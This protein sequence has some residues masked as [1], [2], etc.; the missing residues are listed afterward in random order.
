MLEVPN[1]HGVVWEL[2]H[3]R[4]ESLDERFLRPNSAPPLTPD[5]YGIGGR[6]AA[7]ALSSSAF[8]AMACG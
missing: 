2:R 6:A 7:I 5:G 4:A 8:E 3:S 1:V